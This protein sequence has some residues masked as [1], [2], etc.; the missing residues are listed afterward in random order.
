MKPDW[1]FEPPNPLAIRPEFII[2]KMLR[3]PVVKKIQ[4]ASAHPHG[5][6]GSDSQKRGK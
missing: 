1:G 2:S 3:S 4:Y 6:K 5:L